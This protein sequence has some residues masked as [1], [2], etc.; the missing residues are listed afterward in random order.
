MEFKRRTTRE[1][2]GAS[3]HTKPVGLVLYPLFTIVGHGMI[4]KNGWLYR[5]NYEHCD[6]LAKT[7]GG[8]AA[9][10]GYTGSVGVRPKYLA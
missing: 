9:M 2:P 4:S 7:P 10:D 1:S 8:K 6:L 3:E 5:P